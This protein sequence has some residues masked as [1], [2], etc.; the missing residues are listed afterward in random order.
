MAVNDYLKVERLKPMHLEHALTCSVQNYLIGFYNFRPDS[1]MNILKKTTQ[2]L[3]HF[4]GNRMTP[5]S[6][7]GTNMMCGLLQ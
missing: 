4:S 1:T 7:D 5:S 2:N 3:K 6:N